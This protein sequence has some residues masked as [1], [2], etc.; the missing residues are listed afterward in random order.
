MIG[1]VLSALENITSAEQKEIA[2][3]LHT[4]LNDIEGELD[5]VE[6]PGMYG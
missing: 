5:G 4:A 3:D 1:Q 6:F 2:D